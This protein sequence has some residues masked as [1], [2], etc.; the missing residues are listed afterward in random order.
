M[1]A[2]FEWLLSGFALVLVQIYRTCLSRLKVGRCAHGL[3]HGPGHSCSD[4]A[5]AAIRQ[6]RFAEA[7]VLIVEQFQACRESYH[8]L[9]S[10][11]VPPDMPEVLVPCCEIVYDLVDAFGE[12][13]RSLAKI[14]GVWC[15]AKYMTVFSYQLGDQNLVSSA[16]MAVIAPALGAAGSDFWPV[17]LFALGI[18][19]ALVTSLLR[20]QNAIPFIISQ[21]ALGFAVINFEFVL[22][23]FYGSIFSWLSVASTI[24]EALHVPSL[25]L[26][27]L[28]GPLEPI[29][30][31]ASVFSARFWT[32]ASGAI[33]T[34]LI[35]ASVLGQMSR[36]R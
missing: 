4:F 25:G 33:S 28:R 3:L 22:S 35:I 23:A 26:P 11:R 19:C 12:L 31:I 9:V 2:T 15:V 1:S 29:E 24:Y 30:R 27:T 18:D 34:V 7:K 16:F 17:T 5:L 14:Y 10:G 13:G 21:F 36:Q 8:I 32:L 6:H 20:Q